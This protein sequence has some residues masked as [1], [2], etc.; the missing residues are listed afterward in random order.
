[1]DGGMINAVQQGN[2]AFGKGVDSKCIGE[3]RTGRQDCTAFY[4]GGFLFS[5]CY[6]G[7]K[8]NCRIQRYQGC[9]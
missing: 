8:E 2:H 5:F 7:S 4:R 3:T 1:M 9:Q 6:K